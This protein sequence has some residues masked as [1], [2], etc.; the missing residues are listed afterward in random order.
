MSLIKFF[1]AV[2]AQQ[3]N[4][5]KIIQQRLE[6]SYLQLIDSMRDALAQRHAT[7]YQ[8]ELHEMY[9]ALATSRGLTTGVSGP[10]NGHIT[11]PT[12]SE[13]HHATSS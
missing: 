4:V 11:P 12:T 13:L 1:W 8:R 6:Q 10:Y 9:V 2:W 5:D 3:P 7:E